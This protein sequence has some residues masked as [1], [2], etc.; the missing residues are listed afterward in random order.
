MGVLN[1]TPDSF[2]DGGAYPSLASAIARAEQMVAEGAAIIDI[3]AESTRP[4][5]FPVSL[6]EELDRLI[7]LVERVVQLVPVPVSV[8]TSKPQVMREVLSVGAGLINDVRALQEPGALELMSQFDV[9][10]C[11]MHMRG[12]PATMQDSPEYDDVVADVKAFLDNRVGVCAKH[13][14]GLDRIVVDPGFGFGKTF[15]H[16]LDL[17]R[18]LSAFTDIGAPVMVGMSRK[19]MIGTIV[20]GP[21]PA[22]LF[23]SLAAAVVAVQNGASIV[24]AHDVAATVQS[25]RVC[26][27]VNEIS[28][29]GGA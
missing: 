25:L 1:V 7:P 13:G 26:A 24:R 22:R 8:D 4:G 5:S 18:H 11:L 29:V 2:S 23:G 14:I 12:T 10:V 15:A 27:A 28:D 16:N 9:P 6:Q 19:G 21:P 3:G 20:G 17:L